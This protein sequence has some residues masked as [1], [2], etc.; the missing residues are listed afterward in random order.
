[1]RV[2]D[3]Q[4]QPKIGRAQG[5]GIAC[6]PDFLLTCDDASVRP[7]TVFTDG[8]E[9]HAEP[10]KASSR[11]PDDA[12]KRRALLASGRYWVWSITWH[13]L[14]A[15]P[16]AEMAL[17]PAQVRDVLH[18]QLTILKDHGT[19]CPS[20]ADAAGNGFR[21][22]IAFLARPDANGWTHAAGQLALIPLTILATKHADGAQPSEMLDLHDAWRAGIPVAEM[23]T[24]GGSGPWFHATI[25]APGNDLLVMGRREDVAVGARER[26]VARLRLGDSSNERANAAYLER[27]RRWLGLNNLFQ[28]I[29]AF[30]WFCV[31]EA[32]A[33]AAPDLELRGARTEAADWS[34][35]IGDILPSLR[36]LAEQL[37]ATGIPMPEAEVYLEGAP[38][39]CFAEMAW[40]CAKP[41]VCLLVGD[42]LSFRSSWEESGWTVVTSDEI[43]T[44]GTGWLKSLLAANE[45]A[46]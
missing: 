10:D 46:V 5:V 32:T 45:E 9:F 24:A 26:I 18:K 40:S 11:L 8:F 1:L 39:D 29:T 33:G 19:A 41:A 23:T 31:S 7:V 4:L 17:V 14:I 6:Q 3:I 21:Q 38:D 16:D 35:V 42:Q 30:Q 22:L 25:L 44:N 28:F 2:W 15:V 37:A 43:Q 13:D 20:A 12:L 27:W 36:P 34:A